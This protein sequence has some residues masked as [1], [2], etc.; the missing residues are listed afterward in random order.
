[1]NNKLIVGGIFCDLEKAFDCVNHNICL[2]KLKYEI[3]GNNNAVYKSYLQN[4]YQRVSLHN[5]KIKN[6]I[7]SSWA[8][9]KHG[10]PQGSIIGPVL[11]FIYMNELP[12]AINNKSI[13]VLFADSTSILFTHS[14]LIDLK[15]NINTAQ[16]Q[17]IT[18]YIPEV[19]IIFTFPRLTWIFIKKLFIIQVLKSLKRV[20][21]FF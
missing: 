11:V 17:K 13:P 20:L 3:T 18:V 1:M 4:R 10:V 8:K 19:V 2:S 6:S 5:K 15:K 21:S 7:F 16:I 14:N 12:K 9:V